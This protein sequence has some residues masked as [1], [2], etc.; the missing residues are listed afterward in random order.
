MY[1]PAQYRVRRLVG[2]VGQG[3][4]QACPSVEQLQGI[5]D[6]GDPCQSSSSFCASVAPSI[7]TMGGVNP[8][9]GAVQ[10]S[11]LLPSVAQLQSSLTSGNLSGALPWLVGGVILIGIVAAM[12]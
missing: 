10:P 1:V 11:P 12:R 9:T 6:C 4:G 2:Q 3:L 7:Q 8:L 5:T